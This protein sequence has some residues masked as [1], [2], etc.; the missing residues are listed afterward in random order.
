MTADYE[1]LRARVAALQDR[2]SALS[3]RN[4][5]LAAAVGDPV[6]VGGAH[7]VAAGV[8][9]VLARTTTTTSASAVLAVTDAGT[10]PAARVTSDGVAIAATGQARAA[11]TTGVGLRLDG[12]SA[13]LRLVPQTMD[14][15][16]GEPANGTVA[17]D[18]AGGFYAYAGGNWYRLAVSGGTSGLLMAG[19]GRLFDSRPGT[20]AK[21]GLGRKLKA[22]E[23]LAIQAVS[24]GLLLPAETK[25]VIATITV[26]DTGT[27]GFLK[28]YAAGQQPP[29]TSVTNW[30]R[31]AQTVATTTFVKLDATGR[32]AVQASQPTHLIID[33]LGVVL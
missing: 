2:I 25:A 22:G 3:A 11:S 17:C 31:T 1:A 26:T 9:T 15:F 29:Q 21:V 5:A 27:P 24:S 6:T 10:R 13:P 4:A 14:F 23:V 18:P 33:V 28:A 16:A 19:P 7:Q 20:P 32:L 30:Y 8:S 12:G